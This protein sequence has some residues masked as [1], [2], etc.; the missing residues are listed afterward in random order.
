MQLFENRW[1]FSASDLTALAECSHA[2]ELTH[3]YRA[4]LL[5]LEPASADG[6]VKLAG[7]HGLRH[8]Q[9]VL[10]QLRQEYEVL[11]IEQPD[12]DHGITGIQAAADKTH[13]AMRSGVDV[14]FQGCFFDGRFLGYADFLIRTDEGYEVYDT[15]LAKSAKE[16]ALIQ[17]ASYSDQVE[18]LGFP[19]PVTMHVW[20][21]NGEISSHPVADHLEQMRA[22]RTN[23][24]GRLEQDAHVP[25]PLWADKRGACSACRW[26]EVCADGREIARDLSL[27]HGI[28]GSQIRNFRAVGIRT[29]EQLG[30]ADVDQRPN[31]ISASS[32]NKLSQQARL[33]AMQDASQTSSDPTGHVTAE[34]FA[35]GGVDN[36]PAR[37]DGDV[38]FDIEG[39]PF[40]SEGKGLEYLFGFLVRNVANESDFV[41]LWAH[42]SAQEKIMLEQFVDLMN[43]RINRWPGLH[44]YHYANYERTKLLKL[45][46]QHGTRET[47]VQRWLD[48]KRLVDL[49]KIFRGS[50]RVSQRSYSL[51]KLEPLYGLNREEDVQTAGDS[52]VDYEEYLNLLAKAEVDPLNAEKLHLQAQAKLRGIRDYNEVDC[53]STYLLDTWIRDRMREHRI[54]KL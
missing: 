39:D 32:F 52:V 14:I 2:I 13:Q 51:K 20:L 49:E 12:R 4:G 27:V 45:A 44:I 18:R 46:Q 48:E 1:L 25:D 34:F 43:E 8:E 3:A 31:S 38:W 24:E 28:R 53:L 40:A 11:V 47:Q 41:D 50:F 17:L 5:D 15:K 35:R 42:D 23:L 9:N 26:R 36:M 33:Q 6:M 54:A 7:I 29:V 21:G 16:S 30:E 19:L 22:L 37:S 10:E